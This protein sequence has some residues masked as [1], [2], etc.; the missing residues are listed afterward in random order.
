MAD[1]NGNFIRI[2]NREIYDALQRLDRTVGAMDARVN[3]VLGENVRLSKRIEKLEYRYYG[4]MAG[5]VTA[6]G[7]LVFFVTKGV[8]GG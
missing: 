8:P 3:E 4:L 2:S 7:A 1:D 5:L 6:V